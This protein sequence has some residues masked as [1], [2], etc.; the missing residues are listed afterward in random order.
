MKIVITGDSH[1]GALYL[2]SRTEPDAF[3]SISFAPLGRGSLSAT[4]FF[5]VSDDGKLVT[6]VPDE[7][8]N[9]SFS[10]ADDRTL[11]VVSLPLNTSRIL[12]DR[13]WRTHVPWSL[14]AEQH[15]IALSDGVISAMVDQDSAHSIAFMRALSKA[16]I[17]AVAL[18]APRYF[19]H[20]PHLVRKRPDVCQYV[21][22]FYRTK[23]TAA[24]N[25][26]GIDVITQPEATIEPQGMTSLD[27]AHENPLDTHHANAAY[28]ALA[29]KTVLAYA[30]GLG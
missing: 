4:D 11:L 23:V 12:R 30:E 19:S 26:A 21:D 14:V 3:N 8:L 28:G 15:E 13:S 25:E 1:L 7:W 20:A 9:K 18:E 27:Y 16:G 17:K 22:K 5:D 29:L 2:G 6:T 10:R 24:L